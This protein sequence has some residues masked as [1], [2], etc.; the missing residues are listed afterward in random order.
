MSARTDYLHN[1]IGGMDARF[2]RFDL[3]VFYSSTL[4]AV[5]PNPHAMKTFAPIKTRKSP[6]PDSGGGLF[7]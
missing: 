4:L 5:A 3:N 6:R 2:H 1:V 7:G